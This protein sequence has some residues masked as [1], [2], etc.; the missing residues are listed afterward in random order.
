MS[1]LMKIANRPHVPTRVGRQGYQE[2]DA[3]KVRA[4]VSREGDTNETRS[5]LSRLDRHLSQGQPLRGDVPR[6]YYLNIRV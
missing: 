2:G 3:V 5:A 4:S 1:D 6:G